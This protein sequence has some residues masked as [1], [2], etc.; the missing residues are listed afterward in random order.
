[1]PKEPTMTG[2]QLKQAAKEAATMLKTRTPHATKPIAFSKR[3]KQPAISSVTH[4]RVKDP[5]GCPECNRSS[6]S[7]SAPATI[8]Q[9]FLEAWLFSYRNFREIDEALVYGISSGTAVEPGPRTVELVPI[10]GED[11]N[12]HLRVVVR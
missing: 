7:K 10:R 8:T 5:D 4:G 2:E 11:G 9:D 3:Y 6:S 1:M 12:T